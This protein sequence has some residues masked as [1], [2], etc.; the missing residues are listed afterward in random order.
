M[1][2]KTILTAILAVCLLF[3]GCSFIKDGNEVTRYVYKDSKISRSIEIKSAKYSTYDKK[4][5]KLELEL[6]GNGD[7]FDKK[8]YITYYGKDFNKIDQDFDTSY[9]NDKLVITGDGTEDIDGIEITTNYIKFKIRYL[10]SSQYAILTYYDATDI[11]WEEEGDRELYYTK[12]EL[13]AEKAAKEKAES[14]ETELWNK[15]EGMWTCKTDNNA[16]INFYIDENNSRS[17]AW[18]HTDGS[19]GYILKNISIDKLNVTNSYDGLDLYIYDN[20]EWG[21]QYRFQTNDDM[22]VLTDSLIEN[23]EYVK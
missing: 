6:P 15:L 10:Q 9:S 8:Y 3:T 20:Y 2:K 4:S 1:I 16:Y 5:N 14:T 11:G 18:N 12:E 7:Y 19:G 13:E 17:V 23:N 21:C 22:S